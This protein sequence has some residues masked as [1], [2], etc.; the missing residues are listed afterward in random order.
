MSKQLEAWLEGNGQYPFIQ[1]LM[2]PS[3]LLLLEQDLIKR[4]FQL[5]PI[6]L[7]DGELPTLT[8]LPDSELLANLGRAAAMGRDMDAEAADVEHEVDWQDA[9]EGIAGP[10]GL[11][12]KELEGL[13]GM[14]RRPL[15]DLEEPHE[16]SIDH[17]RSRSGDEGT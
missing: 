12:A 15:T 6:D 14:V 3:A 13:T 9:A 16:V 17:S 5:A 2:H 4:G 1:V 10:D 11:S 8:V 7:G